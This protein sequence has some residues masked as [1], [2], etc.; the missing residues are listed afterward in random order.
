MTES[1]KY[2]L[3]EE[4]LGEL[5]KYLFQEDEHTHRLALD[6]AHGFTTAILIGSPDMPEDEWLAFVWGDEPEFENDEQ[7]QLLQRLLKKMR[8]E[9]AESLSNEQEPFEPLSVEEELDGQSFEN[10]EGWCFGF[11]LGLSHLESSWQMGEQEKELVAPIATLAMLY[12]DEEEDIDDDDYEHC[13]DLLA[14][15]VSELYR[16]SQK[17]HVQ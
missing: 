8:K 15:A 12:N 5:D 9:I 17:R 3:S 4:E 10:F 1:S 14:G 13:I 16:L 7:A 11:M 6:E 2:L